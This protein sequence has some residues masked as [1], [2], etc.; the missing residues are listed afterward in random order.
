MKTLQRQSTTRNHRFTRS[1]GRR[2]FYLEALEE[3]R[4]LAAELIWSPV[5]GSD[6]FNLAGNWV[7]NGTPNRP[8]NPPGA[9]DSVIFVDTGAALTVILSVN[10]KV[11]LIAVV[12]GDVTL[13]LNGNTLTATEI[14]LSVGGQAPESSLTIKG[15]GGTA[16]T[17]PNVTITG[18]NNAGVSGTDL[19][20]FVPNSKATLTITHGANVQMAGGIALGGDNGGGQLNVTDNA[21]LST[22]FVVIG[23]NANHLSGIKVDNATLN[24]DVI[25]TLFIANPSQYQ[26]E[27]NKKPQLSTAFVSGIEI[28]N[29]ATV[30]TQRLTL[31]T[32]NAGVN[33][34]IDGGSRWTT[35]TAQIGGFGEE[36]PI[37]FTVSGA[38]TV[39]DVL[40]GRLEVGTRFGSAKLIVNNNAEILAE[41]I[42]MS[43]GGYS[44][45]LTVSGGATVCICSNTE[46]V[47][48]LTDDGSWLNPR[49]IC[50]QGDP[51]LIE[52]IIDGGN[53]TSE[54]IY[55]DGCTKTR[56][57][58]K[59]NGVWN[60]HSQD[61]TF[62]IGDKD[63][64]IIDL[65]VQRG[66]GS[67][68]FCRRTDE[69]SRNAF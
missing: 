56:V 5:N 26:G 46:T 13:E 47:F 6:N 2:N 39:F 63:K 25:A 49:A 38:N 44:A 54:D 24:A 59:N 9:E 52:V 21:K 18:G 40:M 50:D 31:G 20:T 55:F 51:A 68:I 64:V 10:T 42:L 28:T 48:A 12:S 23:G 41:S 19:A 60:V 53:I 15:N 7:I 57:E 43:G 33:V 32:K 8:A 3:R 30:N 22:P 62:S 58:I 36:N 67:S 17:T 16:P 34:T 37:T 45:S 65:T 11:D 61:P 29:N 66:I 35:D 1:T 27:I 69:E 14:Q 4:L